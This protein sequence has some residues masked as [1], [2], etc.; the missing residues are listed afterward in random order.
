MHKN[1]HRDPFSFDSDSTIRGTRIFSP[2]PES[3]MEDEKS[4]IY[5]FLAHALFRPT[6]LFCTVDRQQDCTQRTHKDSGRE[7]KRRNFIGC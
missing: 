7:G 3:V 6:L 4:R 1:A 2:L 5:D